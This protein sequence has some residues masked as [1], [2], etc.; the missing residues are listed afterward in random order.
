[1]DELTEGLGR[2]FAPLRIEYKS[3]CLNSTVVG[4]FDRYL[5][6]QVRELLAVAPTGHPAVPHLRRMEAIFAAYGQMPVE[7]RAA[8]M[9]EVKRRLD[10]LVTEPPATREPARLEPVTLPAAPDAR[11]EPAA[12][13]GDLN[14]P[15]QYLKGVGPQRAKLLERLGIA[16][17]GDLLFHFPRRHED[18]SRMEL[19]GH[20]PLDELATFE[21][22]VRAVNE[23]RPRRG[24][25]VT[26]AFVGD[27][28]GSITL[29]WFNQPWV[30]EQLERGQPLIFSG[31]VSL[32][33]A[34]R[35]QILHPTWEPLEPG[36][37]SIHTG[38]LVPIYPLTEGLPQTTLRRWIKAALDGYVE[39]VPEVLPASLR[40][41][42][43]LVGRR[44]A[45]RSYHFPASEEELRLARRR[46]VFEEFL[47]LQVA[48][49]Q[50]RYDYRSR[51]RGIAFRTESAL[52]E[53][54]LRRLPFELTCAQ[55]RVLRE[56]LADLAAPEPMNRLVQGDVGSGKTLVALAA[57][58]TVVDQ[59]YQAALMVPTEILAEQHHRVI[60]HYCEPL[61]V[62]VDLFTGRAGTRLRRESR[63][64]LQDGTTRIAVGT[65]ALIQ[66]AIE[67]DS[68]GLV[69]IDEQ[70]RFGVV[71]RQG[72][73]TKGETPDVLVMTATPIPRTLALTVYGD[74]DVSTIDE[75]PPGRQPIT[76][77][78]WP[79]GRRR[80]LYAHMKT[81]LREGRQ[82]F[83]VCPLVEESDALE[84]VEAA[85][86]MAEHLREHF[87]TFEVG[88]IH[89]RLRS[90]EK[91]EVMR[92]FRAGEVDILAA[93]TVI[94][95]GIDVPNATMML[96]TNADRF[97]LAQ[98]HQLRGRVGRGAHESEC[99]LL[100]DARYNPALMDDESTLQY[101][102]ARARLRFMIEYSDGFK[103]AEADLDLR[104]PGELGGTRQSGLMDLR[105]ANLARDRA[106]LEQAREI[107]RTIVQNDPYL[108]AP[109]HA[110]LARYVNERFRE[111]GQLAEV[112]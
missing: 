18:R 38:R 40:E 76:T 13:R 47:G 4:G 78:W 70:H 109:A 80:E 97:G 50:R 106:L 1:M 23:R 41:E 35:R 71:Q 107:A 93:T 46:L 101:R 24:L 26:T 22:R 66:E 36:A 33:R 21:G 77:Q 59:G 28:S 108:V 90:E 14:S 29:V 16:T 12:P 51:G 54:L 27:A 60:R 94:E 75:M 61:G 86:A 105:V 55:Q 95:V 2:L 102:D 87:P 69:V 84:D 34:G 25:T 67:F 112:G 79:L 30:A 57:M 9:R 42:L 17:I 83:V 82:A 99:F 8:R 5:L 64:R 56:I 96:I 39:R 91:D 98:L 89:G 31:K 62:E 63:Q 49:A 103:L 44:E 88:L 43:A 37:E 68:L 104:G 3:G 81:R 100:T 111:R 11:A 85:T 20:A 74:L 15:V 72:L 73:T 58:L 53:R 19:I 110:E 65:H 7:E 32:D 45:L 48:I 6:G 10:S 92:R 52:R